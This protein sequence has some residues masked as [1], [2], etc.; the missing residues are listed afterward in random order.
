MITTLS[1]S[2]KKTYNSLNISG[3]QLILG[4]SKISDE[5]DNFK[6]S[7]LN[8]LIFPLISKDWQSLNENIYSLDKLKTKIDTY[9]DSYKLD[10]LL[11]Y[12]EVMN[13]IEIV[14]SEHKELE[15]LEKKIYGDTTNLSTMIYKT[16]MIKLKPEYEI[17]NLIIGKPNK[18]QNEIYVDEILKD[19]ENLL[20]QDDI[21]F[22]RIKDF[23]SKKYFQQ[24]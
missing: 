2:G 12:K 3:K 17:Y 23:I 8:N 19:I 9:Y 1:L 14:V 13:A 10:D 16:A 20:L 6:I 5:I 24:N 4:K 11:I 7:I 15:G 21:S 18:A 22:N